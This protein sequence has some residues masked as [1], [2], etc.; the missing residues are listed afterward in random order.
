MPGK[1]KIEIVE[2]P[3]Q[4]KEF[5]FEE[6]DTFLFGRMPDCHAVLPDDPLVSRHQFIVEANPPDACVRDLGSL[7]GTYVNDIKHG[8]REKGETPEQGAKRQYPEVSLKTGDRIKVGHTVM[9]I[10]T[11]GPAIC[12]ECDCDIPEENRQAYAWVGGTFICATCKNKLISLGKPAKPPKPK[13]VHCQKCGKDVTDEVGEGRKGDYICRSCQKKAEADPAEL[14]FAI[15]QKLG[16]GG[17]GGEAPEVAGYKIEKKIGAGGFGAVYLARHETD[18]GHVAV[19]VMLSQV[20]V[21]EHSRK[22]FLREMDSMKKLKHDHIV[23]LLDRGSAGGA[24]YFIMDYCEGGSVDDLIRQCGGKLALSEAGPIILDALAGL[25]YAHQQNFVHRDLKPGNILLAGPEGKRVAKVTDFGLAK[26][27]QKAGL[28]GMTVTGN[29]AGTPVYMPR[30]QV[31]NFKYVKPASDVWSMGA[32]LYNMLTGR[33]PRDMRRGQDPME[34]ILHG[35][36]VPIRKRDSG[37]PRKVAEVIDRA[38]DNNV[39]NRYKDAAGMRKA[40]AKAL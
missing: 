32:T 39:K 3:M 16:L 17:G 37:I 14:M 35:E 19:K 22:L 7:N 21:D 23:P 28:S 27:F 29:V 30:E 25:A 11:E 8:G 4:G 36:I 20:A 40:L 12:C 15:M 18:G 13:P 26:N 5:V 10:S 31:T 38:L 34:A 24:F 1:V 9:A 33:F 6:H 2:G